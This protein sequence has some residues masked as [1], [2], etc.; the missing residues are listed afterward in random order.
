M[1][2]VG[3]AEIQNSFKEVAKKVM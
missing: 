1:E 3:N 2:L